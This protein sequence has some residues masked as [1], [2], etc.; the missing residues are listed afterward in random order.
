MLGVIGSKQDA[1]EIQRAVQNFIKEELKLD[2][3]ERKGPIL[4]AKSE[5]AKY[6]GTLITYYGTGSVMETLN[7]D[8]VTSKQSDFNR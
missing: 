5:M 1:L 8:K 6:L 7:T 3:K 4:S 2:M